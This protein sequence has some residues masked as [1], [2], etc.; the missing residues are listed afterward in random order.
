[1]NDLKDV[2]K[3]VS[4]RTVLEKIANAIEPLERLAVK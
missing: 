2:E 4:P 3:L 1:M